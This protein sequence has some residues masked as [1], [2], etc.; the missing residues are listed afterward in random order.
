MA[1]SYEKWNRILTCAQD[2]LRAFAYG[3]SVYSLIRKTLCLYVC[4]IV[5]VVCMCGVC[6]YVCVYV[7]VILC[8]CV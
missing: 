3:A 7:C 8:V 5:C 6:V 4:V 1:Y 2:I